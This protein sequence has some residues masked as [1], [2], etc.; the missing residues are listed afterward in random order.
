V[1]GVDID[2]LSFSRC[3][4]GLKEYG[5][6][7]LATRGAAP[8]V[9]QPMM[10]PDAPKVHSGAM[11]AAKPIRITPVLSNLSRSPTRVDRPVP[12]KRVK[13][14]TKTALPT[15]AGINR[16]SAAQLAGAGMTA[17]QMLGSV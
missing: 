6:R 15:I 16:A 13:S 14:P 9:T 7:P 17:G 11:K 3:A 1:Y 10:K 2:E 8:R 12:S 5:E 4:V